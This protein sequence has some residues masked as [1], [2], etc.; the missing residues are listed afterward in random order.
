MSFKKTRQNGRAKDTFYR[1][2]VEMEDD[3]KSLD[4]N[5]D[6]DGHVE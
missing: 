5:L 6:V 1:N 2:Y 4:S 3:P